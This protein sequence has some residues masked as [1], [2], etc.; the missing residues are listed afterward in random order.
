MK[1]LQLLSIHDCSPY[2]MQL[3]RLPPN[4]CISYNYGQVPV[5]NFFRDLAGKTMENPLST[6]LIEFKV[7]LDVI[8]M[9]LQTVTFNDGAKVIFNLAYYEQ[10]IA[11]TIK[12]IGKHEIVKIPPA[13][14]QGFRYYNN[15]ILLKE[16]VKLVSSKNTML[17]GV[18]VSIFIDNKSV[19]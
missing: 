15:A 12:S 9:F 14:I 13:K 1:H 11:T 17:T 2:V 8:K 6:L 5:A 7:G 19:F 18:Y 4:L 16:N 10:N 3:P